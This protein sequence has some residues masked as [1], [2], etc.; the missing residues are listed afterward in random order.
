[1]KMNENKLEYK[2]IS[3]YS[4]LQPKKFFMFD[5]L[6]GYPKED[7]DQGPRPLVRKN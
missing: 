5:M 3:H 2:L 7:H 1:M 4:T 6:K